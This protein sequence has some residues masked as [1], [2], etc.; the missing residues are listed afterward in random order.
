MA[1]NGCVML[2]NCMPGE[3]DYPTT[4]RLIE[5]GREH[6]LLGGTVD[7]HCPT[8]LLHGCRTR[9]CHGTGGTSAENG[10]GRCSRDAG[11]ERRPPQSARE[12]HPALPQCGRYAALAKKSALAREI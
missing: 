1:D 7:I 9:M 5:E 2:P 6:L 4:R 10:A 12:P 11:E 8:H 3:S